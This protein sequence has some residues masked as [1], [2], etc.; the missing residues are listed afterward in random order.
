M[1]KLNAKNSSNY[2]LFPP[3][4]AVAPCLRTNRMKKTGA[5]VGSTR[6]P[7]GPANCMEVLQKRGPRTMPEVYAITNM[8]LAAVRSLPLKDCPTCS[9]P[10]V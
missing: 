4:V 7:E 10:S 2:N 3:V 1:I 8:E 5:T 6:K 9:M